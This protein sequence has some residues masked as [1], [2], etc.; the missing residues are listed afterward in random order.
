[1]LVQCELC[2]NRAEW[3]MDSSQRSG[4]PAG[5]QMW[6]FVGDGRHVRLF[7]CDGCSTGLERYFHSALPVMVRELALVP[8]LVDIRREVCCRLELP[9][10]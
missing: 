8:A 1:M 9:T 10:E 7:A 6:S 2:D 4:M 3:V 5:W